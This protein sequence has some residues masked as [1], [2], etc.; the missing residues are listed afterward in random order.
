MYPVWHSIGKSVLVIKQNHQSGIQPYYFQ[1]YTLQVQ[2]DVLPAQVTNFSLPA[3]TVTEVL[4]FGL[5]FLIKMEILQ[6]IRK[7]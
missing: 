4:F 3:T 5:A 6:S 1:E 7:R 2:K